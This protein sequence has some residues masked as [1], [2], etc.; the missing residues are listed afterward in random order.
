MSSSD[1]EGASDASPSRRQ[2][3]WSGRLRTAG[4]LLLLLAAAAGIDALGGRAEVWPVA[5]GLAAAVREQ[6]R[7][8]GVSPATLFHL[9]FARVLA[10]LAGRDDVVFGTVLF[11]RMHGAAGADRVLGLFMNTLPVRVDTR[12]GDVTDAVAGMRSQ[13][14]GLLA[15]EHAPLAL[16]Q[17]ASGVP[18]HAPLFTA[19]FNFRH[20]THRDIRPPTPGIT[21]GLV[22]DDTNY[23]LSVGVTD[24]GD[25]FSLTIDAVPP[26]DPALV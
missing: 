14:A 11:G 25:G 4:A 24:T 9:A 20:N 15:H 23:P 19:L 1:A 7:R 26:G 3:R 8:A 12:S 21:E 16:A 2:K 18:P 17:Q 22:R 5:A 6:A 13:L 10:V